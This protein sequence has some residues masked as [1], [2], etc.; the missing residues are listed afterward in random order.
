MFQE[1]VY[2]ELIHFQLSCYNCFIEFWGFMFW[3]VV[4]DTER[5]SIGMHSYS[6]TV[7]T[8]CNNWMIMLWRLKDFDEI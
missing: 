7:S 2:I 1:G 5:Y 8:K 6:E 3:L 4:Y